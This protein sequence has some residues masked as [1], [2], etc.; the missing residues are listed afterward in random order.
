MKL[1][2][3]L[4]ENSITQAA[5]AEKIGS[6]QPQVARFAVGSRIPNRDTMRRIVAATEGAVGPTD[7][8]EVQAA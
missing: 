6:S 1:A 5:F 4:S 8:Y 7:F 3:W 2:A